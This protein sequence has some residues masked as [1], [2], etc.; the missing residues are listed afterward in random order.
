MADCGTREDP[1]LSRRFAGQPLYLTLIETCRNFQNL[2][3]IKNTTHAAEKTSRS[4]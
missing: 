3:A 2:R 4:L 1:A